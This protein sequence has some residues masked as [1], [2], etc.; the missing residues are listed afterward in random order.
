MDSG[1][2]ENYLDAVSFMWE[3]GYVFETTGSAR[4][5]GVAE[6]MINAGREGMRQF[7]MDIERAH[8][9]QWQAFR[10][11]GKYSADCPSCPSDHC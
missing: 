10:T 3:P 4:C 6:A 5:D 11:T 9:E 7:F 2:I 1:S 8:E